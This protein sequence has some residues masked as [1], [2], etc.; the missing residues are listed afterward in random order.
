M[1]PWSPAFVKAAERGRILPI[2]DLEPANAAA[3]CA[4][5]TALD[6]CVKDWARYT[7]QAVEFHLHNATA[8]ANDRAGEDLADQL[9]PEFVLGPA[10]TL[11]VR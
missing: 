10:P 6:S 4:I 2:T 3:L 11:S 7:A 8:W 9:D 5:R 1:S